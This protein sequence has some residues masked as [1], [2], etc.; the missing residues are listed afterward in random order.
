MRVSRLRHVRPS[1]SAFKGMEGRSHPCWQRGG[2]GRKHPADRR[3]RGPE[4]S[5]ATAGEVLVPA[6]VPLPIEAVLQCATGQSLA[7]CCR[8][9]IAAVT[10]CSSI[11]VHAVHHAARRESKRQSDGRSRQQSLVA[12][13]VHFSSGPKTPDT[14]AYAAVKQSACLKAVSRVASRGLMHWR[15]SAR[16]SR[17]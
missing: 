4:K 13:H 17:L 7:L 5:H 16:Q 2:K 12:H 8:S 11:A 3:N 9:R 10:A 14:Y 1:H 15:L 6:A